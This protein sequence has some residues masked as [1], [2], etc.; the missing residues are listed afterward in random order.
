MHK[1]C[2]YKRDRVPYEEHIKYHPEMSYNLQKQI[3]FFSNIIL[4]NNII[5]DMRR[6]PIE[7]ARTFNTY[8]NGAICPNIDDFYQKSTKKINRRILKRQK[9]LVNVEKARFEEKEKIKKLQEELRKAKKREEE[10]SIAQQNLK[11]E[12]NSEKVSNLDIQKGYEL[13]LENK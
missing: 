4:D 2:N 8:T 7:V 11:N 5:G 10:L 12:N 1:D 6:W 9:E 13:L 3:D